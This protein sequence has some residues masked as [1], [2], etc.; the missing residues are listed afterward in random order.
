GIELSRDARWLFINIPDEVIRVPV[1]GGTVQTVLKCDFSPDNLRWGED[2]RLYVGGFY[3]AEGPQA[4]VDCMKAT[5]CDEGI[6]V[7]SIDADS[8]AAKQ[9]VRMPGI[10]G[11]FGLAT[12]ALQV[13]NSLW[14]GTARGDRVAILPFNP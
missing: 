6:A 14:M 3:S 7:A 5:L 8:L 10:K 4:E 12:T 1:H 11:R 13:G 9:V 2:G